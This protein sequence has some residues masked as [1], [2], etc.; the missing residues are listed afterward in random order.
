MSIVFRL[1]LMYFMAML[2]IVA[3]VSHFLTPEFYLKMM[4]RYLPYHLEL[5]Y[6]SGLFEIMCGLLLLFARTQVLGVWLTITLLIAVCKSNP[7]IVCPLSSFILAFT[8]PANIQ[9]AQD[10][11]STNHNQKYF[12][13]VRLPMQFVLIWWAYQY[14][15]PV[16]HIK[17]N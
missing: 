7:S 13:L 11:W 10:Y 4:P 15:Q 6:L 8:V 17:T 12:T 3:G 5:V 2:Y 9:M 1:F 14:R 16:Q